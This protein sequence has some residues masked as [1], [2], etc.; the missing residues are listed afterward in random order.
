LYRAL[1]DKKAPQSR[2]LVQ[3]TWDPR[4]LKFLGSGRVLMAHWFRQG[5]AGEGAGA[6]RGP[7]L[8]KSL[9]IRVFK[10]IAKDRIAILF[11]NTAYFF[12]LN[13]AILLKK[14]SL[15]NCDTF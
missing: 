7:K 6:P 2:F 5:V 3:L 12:T 1:G 8:K 13:F 10:G 11:S 14:F 15:R 9:H 4:A